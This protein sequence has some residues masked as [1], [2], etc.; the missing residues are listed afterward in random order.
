MNFV[1]CFVKPFVPVIIHKNYAVNYYFI[2]MRLKFTYGA[3]F[4][5]SVKINKPC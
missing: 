4:I 5:C 2:E 3:C 1:K